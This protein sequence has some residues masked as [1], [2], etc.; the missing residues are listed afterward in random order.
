VAH[1]TLSSMP[2]V[3]WGCFFNSLQY[4]TLTCSIHVAR[5]QA[6]QIPLESLRQEV[7]QEYELSNQLEKDWPALESKIREEEKVSFT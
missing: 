3:L 5:N 4:T 1:L 2:P 7:M 6:L